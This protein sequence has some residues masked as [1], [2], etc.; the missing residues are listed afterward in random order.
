M[1]WVVRVCHFLKSGSS[2]KKF[3]VN[4]ESQMVNLLRSLQKTNWS[5][6]SRK[7]HMAANDLHIGSE[8][9]LGINV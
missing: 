2:E 5:I 7:D 1:N 4:T 3:I 9:L 8:L 6:L